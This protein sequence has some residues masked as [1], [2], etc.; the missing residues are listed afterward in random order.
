MNV[1]DPQ[2][3]EGTVADC[4]LK[5]ATSLSAEVAVLRER[6]EIVERLAAMHGLFGPQDVDNFR[7]DPAVAASFKTKRKALIERV[8][9]TMRG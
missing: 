3:P 9:G 8:F 1:Q 7:P 6:L 4:S 5:I 2:R